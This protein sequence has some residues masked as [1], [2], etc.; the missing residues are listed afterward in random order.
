M[1]NNREVSE[2]LVIEEIVRHA[3]L[4]QQSLVRELVGHCSDQ[5]HR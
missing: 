5:V 3:L 4:T 1:K 2:Q